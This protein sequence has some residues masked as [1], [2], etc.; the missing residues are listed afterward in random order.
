MGKLGDQ[1][2]GNLT[3][4][5]MMLQVREPHPDIGCWWALYDYGQEAIGSWAKDHV[6]AYP[7]A[8]RP[9]ALQPESVQTTLCWSLRCELHVKGSRQIRNA[10]SP[11]SHPFLTSPLSVAMRRYTLAGCHLGIAAVLQHV[12]APQREAQASFEGPDDCAPNSGIS[13]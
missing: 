9:R 6:H 5:L 13:A 10:L 8:H 4:I 1:L 11:E 3:K 2:T 12:H 7:G